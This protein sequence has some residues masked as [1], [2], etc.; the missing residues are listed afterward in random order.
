M[1][2]WPKLTKLKYIHL[3]TDQTIPEILWEEIR[4]NHSKCHM[5]VGDIDIMNFQH[6]QLD[7]KELFDL[8]YLTSL[9]LNFEKTESLEIDQ[10]LLIET[11]EYA[12]AF[13]PNLRH[14]GIKTRQ[15][16]NSDGRWAIEFRRI[17]R[18]PKTLTA[19]PARL[20]SLALHQE[21]LNFRT[22]PSLIMQELGKIVDIPSLHVLKLSG[23]L[24]KCL[25]WAAEN[26]SF[27]NLL[28]FEQ[29]VTFESDHG[30]WRGSISNL[31]QLSSSLPPLSTFR[32]L[33]MGIE[34]DLPE[35][36]WHHGVKLTSLTIYLQR[37]IEFGS[38]RY[39]NISAD[40]LKLIAQHCPL[41]QYFEGEVRREYS[42]QAEKEVYQAFRHF[43]CLQRVKLHIDCFTETK[44]LSDLYDSGIG[45]SHGDLLPPLMHF[46]IAKDVMNAAFDE[47]LASSIWEFMSKDKKGRPLEQLL[48][49][50]DSAYYPFFAA[51]RPWQVRQ[52]Y[53]WL[54]DVCR[55]YELVRAVETG[56]RNTFKIS[57]IPH[58][59]NPSRGGWPHPR[60]DQEFL[61][62][63]C[64]VEK[65]DIV[66]RSVIKKLWGVSVYDL[67]WEKHCT[68]IPFR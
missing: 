14:I 22:G 12:L 39:H 59:G 28:E 30:L 51:W 36:L 61:S 64:D 9:S 47:K 49:L 48:L 58:P 60:Y 15:W 52:E 50:P 45:A 38:E 34:S 55:S 41:L 35:I 3:A 4:T 2:L 10:A 20:R 66:E 5:E 7:F 19:K 62:L 40:T 6:Y 32:L 67:G 43:G 54:P 13:A 42:G 24:T 68:G 31:K 26:Y 17:I 21:Q 56:G 46:F 33:R 27:T 23:F 44:S 18:K 63:R 8:P 11:L 16:E 65:W 53:I 1:N 57:E 37:N 29:N 25:L